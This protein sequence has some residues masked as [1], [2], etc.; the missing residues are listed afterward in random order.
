MNRRIEI[1][2]DTKGAA[3]VETRGFA[4]SDCMEAS[5]FI[6]KALGT[7]GQVTTTPEY[8]HATTTQTQTNVQNGP[9]S[10]SA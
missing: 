8:F 6:E 5:R 7:A 3:R 1:I 9:T 4:G 2:V 10:G